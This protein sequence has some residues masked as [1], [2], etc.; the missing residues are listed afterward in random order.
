MEECK[1]ICLIDA[2]ILSYSVGFSTQKTWYCV[3]DEDTG[4]GYEF[5]TKKE[6]LEVGTEIVT[7]VTALEQEWAAKKLHEAVKRIKTK[8]KCKEARLLLTGKGNFRGDVAVSYPYKGN[9]KADK[10]VHYQ[11]LRDLMVSHYDAEVI[12]GEEADD[13]LGYMQT[14][15]TIIASIDKD[16]MM[17]PGKHY[18]M[19]T[20]KKTL[21]TDPGKLK[22]T[23]TKLEGFGFKWFCA[24][25]LLGD[26]TDNIKGVSGL[27]NVKTFKILKDI[28]DPIGMWETVEKIYCEKDMI[29]RIE[30]N[31][32]LL[33]IRREKGQHP[34]DFIGGLYD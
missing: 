34:F 20:G 5:G 22:L 29:H 25:M 18:N 31:A 1:M 10:P 12:E 11:F 4:F 21:A 32:L 33:W 3:E 28:K 6:A 9:R 30:E 14:G 24:Q 15:N 13:A 2:D 27:G 8:T 19:M 17:I 16:L 26:P 7:I 23:D